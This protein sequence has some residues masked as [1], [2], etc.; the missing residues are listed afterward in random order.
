MIN[1]ILVW[2]YKKGN[3]LYWKSRYKIYK[4]KYTIKSDFK[5]NGEFIEFYGNGKIFCGSN[6]YIGHYSTVQADLDCKVVIGDFCSIS[7]NV[8]IYTSSAIPDQDFRLR[9]LHIKKGDVIIE[10]GVW[11]GANVFIN[12]GV[13][14]GSNAIVGSNSVVTKDVKKFTIV[15]GV[16]AKLIREKRIV[17]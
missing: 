3:K 9:P 6:S 13:R 17:E 15:G 1:D 7:H 14:I 8:R 11:I 12:P 2:L 16:P 10:D 5:F 4:S